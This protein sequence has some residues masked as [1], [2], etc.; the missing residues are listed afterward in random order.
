MKR[1]IDRVLR[2]FFTFSYVILFIVHTL[3]VCMFVIMISP[4][5]RKGNMA[6]YASKFWSLFNVFLSGTRIVIHGKDKIEKGRTYIIMSNHQ[7]LFDVL[8]LIGKLPLQIRWI[9]KSEIRKIPVF[10]YTLER[11]GHIYIDRKRRED[12]YLSL[13]TAVRKIKEGT[14]VVIFPEGTRSSNGRLLKFRY[15]GAIMAIKSGVPIL[16]ITVNGGRFVLPRDTL[17]LRPGRIKIIVGDTID[18]GRFDKNSKSEL[19]A[20]V[21][22]AIDKNLDLEYGANQ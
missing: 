22:S 1:T 6:C 10:G 18:P 19:M 15:G 17:S 7:S 8:A 14:S 12:A 20:H 16:P 21:K 5:D 3:L 13:D 11:V 9:I 4:F 2:I